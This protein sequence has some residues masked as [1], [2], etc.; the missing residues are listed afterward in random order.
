MS[1]RG[2]HGLQKT[3]GAYIS[4]LSLGGFDDILEA[5][6]RGT[7]SSANLQLTQADFTSITTGANTIVFAAGSPI[8]L[9]VKVGDVWRLTNHSSAANNSINLR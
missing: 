8:S 4:E 9:G 2:R 3:A 7:W 6:M 1:T 5:V